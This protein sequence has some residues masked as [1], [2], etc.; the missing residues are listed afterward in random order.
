MRM[1]PPSLQVQVIAHTHAHLIERIKFLQGRDAAMAADIVT[2]SAAVT[3]DGED[4]IYAEGDHAGELYFVLSGAVALS[5]QSQTGTGIDSG[6][7]VLSA[8]E[9]FGEESLFTQTFLATATA[10]VSTRCL[11]VPRS[12]AREV[13]AATGTAAVAGCC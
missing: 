2:N 8:G 7:L 3:F 1:L 6:K 9:M 13:R 11:A 10:V 5:M 4:V 12:V